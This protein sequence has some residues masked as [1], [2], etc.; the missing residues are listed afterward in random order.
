M[1]MLTITR[2][3]HRSLFMWLATWLSI[4]AQH[5]FLLVI[6]YIGFIIIFLMKMCIGIFMALKKIAK[7]VAQ[8]KLHFLYR[9]IR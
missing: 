2:N 7:R 4:P 5:N 8:H 9:Y 6:Q 3:V 1:G